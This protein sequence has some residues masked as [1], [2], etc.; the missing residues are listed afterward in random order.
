M[1][2]NDELTYFQNIQCVAYTYFMYECMNYSKRGHGVS[3][4]FASLC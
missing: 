2:T 1:S 3:D 4:C